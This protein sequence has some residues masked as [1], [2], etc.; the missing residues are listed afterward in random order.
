M[1]IEPQ[2]K[3]SIPVNGIKV[4]GQS[5][6]DAETRSTKSLVRIKDGDTVVLSGLVKNKLQEEKS[7]I[8]GVGDLPIVGALFRH[9]NIQPNSERELLVFITPH[10]V[11][12]KQQEL[13]SKVAPAMEPLP[14]LPVR[15]QESVSVLD[16]QAIISSSLSSFQKK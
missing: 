12:D 10:I 4:A 5:V 1:Y 14:K 15:E 2:I 9:K 7:Q 8:P 11:K 3:D 13:A 6:R 16:R